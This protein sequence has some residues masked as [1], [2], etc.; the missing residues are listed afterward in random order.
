MRARLLKVQNLGG[1]ILLEQMVYLYRVQSLHMQISAVVV[2]ISLFGTL[3][4]SADLH[5][6]DEPKQSA[7]DLDSNLVNKQVV[8]CSCSSRILIARTLRLKR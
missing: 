4:R 5:G 8:I 7:L 6:D 2:F 1:S 3:I